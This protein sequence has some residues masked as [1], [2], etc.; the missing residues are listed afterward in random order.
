[1]QRAELTL[2]VVAAVIAVVIAGCGGG[3]VSSATGEI[4]VTVVFPEQS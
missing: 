4:A 3:S 2:I 1:M